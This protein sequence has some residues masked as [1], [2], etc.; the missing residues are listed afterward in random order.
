MSA[1]SEAVH[2]ENVQTQRPTPK[3]GPL[4]GIRV[5]D[6]AT[7]LAGPFTAVLLGDYGAEVIKIE[8]PRGDP[9]RQHG[10]R[11]NGVGLWWKVL[12]RNKLAITLDLHKTEGQEILL[13]LVRKSD[14]LIENF[15]PGIMESWNLPYSRLFEANRGLVM[16]RTT[17]FGQ[18]GPYA[19]RPGYGTLAE[20]MSGFA[21]LTGQ[22][23]G[24]PTL[25]P[26]G[27]A[28]GIAGLAGAFA[29]MMALFHRDA[30]QGNGQVIDLAII[31]PMLMI[32]GSQPIVY[33]QLGLIL[34]R[35]GNRSG[36]N[37][38]R[39]TY[40][41]LDG[42]WVAVSASAEAIA[43]RVMR[44]VGHPEVIEESWFHL[45]GERAKH[46]DELDEMVGGW[47]A[48]RNLEEVL[49]AFERA[50]AA[51]APIYD[52]KQIMEDPQFRALGTFIGIADD[53]LGTLKMQNVPFRMSDTP[54][55]VRFPGHRLGQDNR[56]VYGSLLNFGDAHLAELSEA[57]VI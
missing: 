6:L 47:I 5:L 51:I 48:Q 15:R 13:E 1:C 30:R 34:Q 57:G 28:D 8:H 42:R 52:I 9:M 33:D 40:R 23:D 31:E 44:L 46:A 22:P 18:F 14:V 29:V 45:A 56:N 49:Q 19:P 55:A 41:T 7:M 20:S 3:D 10:H 2:G 24:P 25:P 26:F 27:L 17:G 12:A 38:P 32:L 36:T 37:A 50:D 43:Q 21:H 4:S 16:L 11:K 54:G 39:N 35:M 53:E